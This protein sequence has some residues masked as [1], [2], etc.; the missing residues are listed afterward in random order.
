MQDAKSY[1]IKWADTEAELSNQDL[2]ASGLMSKDIA[3]RLQVMA[4][5]M[6][7]G[8]IYMS[9]AP[10]AKQRLAEIGAQWGFKEEQ[11]KWPVRVGHWLEG[12]SPGQPT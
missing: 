1:E 12:K 3:V 5:S 4:T 8:M 2:E 11:G 7:A 10:V 6:M 9:I